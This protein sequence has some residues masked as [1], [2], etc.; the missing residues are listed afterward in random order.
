MNRA[1]C[2]S[3]YQDYKYNVQLACRLQRVQLWKGHDF[4]TVRLKSLGLLDK[5]A[6][7]AEHYFW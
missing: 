5:M 7:K 6:K 3:G 4:K 2:L 1:V